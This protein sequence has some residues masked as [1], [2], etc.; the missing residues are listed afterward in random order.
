[1]N[2]EIKNKKTIKKITG[3][4]EIKSDSLKIEKSKKT[5]SVTDKTEVKNQIQKKW[6]LIDANEKTA[7]K[8]ATVASIYLRGKNTPSFDPSKDNGNFVVIINASKIKITGNKLKNKIFYRHTGYPKG[9]RHKTLSEIMDT[10]PEQVLEKAVLGMM[11]KNKLSS[12]LLKRLKVYAEEEHGHKNAK[13]I[14]LEI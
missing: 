3:N 8:I 9:L 13:F 10:K 6:Y 1:M 7:G 12:R 4:S 5:V 11:P 2:K 14:E